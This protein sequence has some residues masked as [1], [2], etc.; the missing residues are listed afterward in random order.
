MSVTREMIAAAQNR[1]APYVRRT[2]LMQLADPVRCELKLE[3]LQVTGSFKAR[4]AFNAL[5]SND[6]PEA[7]VAAASGGNHGAAVAHAATRLGHASAI[8]VPTIA[9]RAKLRV[10]EAAMGDVHI[11]GDRYADAL[12]ACEAFQAETGAISIHAYDSPA[13]VAGQGTVAA[14]WE[15]DSTGLDTVLV[16]VGGGGLIS[17]V[18]SWFEDRVKVVGV[19]PQGSA[20]LHAALA[21]GGPVDVEVDSIAA[22]SLGAKRTG[23]LNHAIAARY[24]DEVV[25]VPDHSIV[26]AMRTLWQTARLMVEPGGATAFAALQSGAYTPRPGER[27]GVLVCG[28]NTDPALFAELLG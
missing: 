12:A 10:I 25:L 22:D 8:F 21:A 11:G 9:S 7:G 23:A 19:E 1:I 4:G 5:L 27:V 2:P 6:V 17:G 28:G 3:L 15:A 20:C 13:T 24:V 16:A 26:E 18:A 14:E